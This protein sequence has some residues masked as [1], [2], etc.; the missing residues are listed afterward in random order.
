MEVSVNFSIQKE[1]KRF[2]EYL[3]SLNGVHIVDIS[4]A[5]RRENWNRYYWAVIVR[6]ASQYSGNLPKKQHEL[7][8]AEFAAIFHRDLQGRFSYVR[9]TTAKMSQ[10]V[11][12]Q[13]CEF[14]KMAIAIRFG[15]Y[16]PDIH[17]IHEV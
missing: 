8:L 16:T 17:E 4:K 6:L 5:T 10:E 7:F 2:I 11:F 3:D 9:G 13:Y 14:C 15:I 12:V 1:K